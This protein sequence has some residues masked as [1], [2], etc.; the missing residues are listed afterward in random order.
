[1]M[2]RMVGLLLLCGLI[3]PRAASAE[4]HEVIVVFK[5][6]FDIG[7]TDMAANVVQRYRTTMID[8]ALEVV[9]RNRDLPPA[10]QFVWTIPGWPMHQILADWPGQTPQRQEQ[11]K[12]ALAE[13]RFVVH[14]LPFTT[15]TE[16]LEVEDLVRGLGYSSRLARGLG[17]ALP[18]DAKMTDVPEHTWMLSTLLRHAGVRFMHIG[19]NGWSAPL[20]VPPL[21][22]WEGPD[23]SRTLT[24]YSPDY[25]TRLMPPKDWP[26]NTW[27]ALL[28]TGDNEGPPRPEDVK[29]VLDQAAQE[30]PGVKVRIGRLSDFADALEAEKADLPVIR[31]D[32][33]DTW[34]HGPMSDPAGSKIA[35][36]L[37]PL[38]AATESLN[39]QLR[40]WGVT[41]PDATSTV[42]AAYEQSLL[43]G[44]HTWGGM[45]WWAGFG[46]IEGPISFGADFR[47][48]RASGRFRKIEAS[49]DEHTAYIEKAQ[50]L[51]TPVLQENLEVLARSVGHAGPRIV[52]YNP[53]PWKRDGLVSIPAKMPDAGALRPVDGGEDLAVETV[54]GQLRFVARDVPPM[55]YRT[56]VPAPR[57]EGVPPLLSSSSEEKKQGQDALAT[58]TPSNRGQD[59]RDT[60]DGDTIETAQF[61][62]TFDPA[63]GIVRSL[64][65]KASGRELVDGTKA[66]GFGQYLYERFDTKQ[67]NEYCQAYLRRP[68]QV[69]SPVFNKT[70]HPPADKFPYRA[71]SP[72]DFQLRVERSAVSVAVVME[73]RAQDNLPAV[74]TRVVLYPDQPYLDLEITLHDKP[75]DAVAEAGWLCLPLKVDAPQFRLGRLA[76]IIDPTRDILPGANRHVFGLNSGLA[77]TD[78]PG[79]GVGLCPLDSPLVSLDTPGLWKYTHDFVPRQP[80]VYVN[81]F[82]NQWNTNF[83]LWNSGTWTSRVR[84]WP[85]GARGEGVPPLRR[86]GILPAG[87]K[88]GQDALATEEQ[89][90]D[91][92]ATALITPALE[93]RYPLQAARADGPGGKLPAAQRG[94][95]LSPKGVLVTAFGR[96]P[97][98]P[99]TVLRLWEYA[100]H[101]GTCRVRLPAGLDI[102]QVQAVS[103][104][105]EP[106][107]APIPVPDGVF[108]VNLTGFA[109]AS[110]IIPT[111]S[112][113]RP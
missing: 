18:H 39:T 42:A 62:A 107:G 5:T 108:T 75:A 27:L 95:E 21:F 24:M 79:R 54:D 48:D 12:Q 3:V 6:H 92:L 89:G 68:E 109:P 64:V 56:Y 15:H 8:Q 63:R 80:I 46:R 51:L 94:L 32:A 2:K 77:V 43:Y 26:C 29:K 50:R 57:G 28:H 14:A 82:N 65:E 97:D 49:W 84:L 44:E 22:W 91:A 16:L 99:G 76:S 81:L 60:P 110:F 40:A 38:I 67:M 111:I 98:G 105:G 25:G 93:A 36:N 100:G 103:L 102:E 19:C 13:G 47:E 35:R 45:G 37:R 58:R 30:L 87:E 55:G 23:G 17:L 78:P 70:S 88:Q 33:P 10:Q 74:T 66:V 101:S 73:S 85:I 113:G 52:V 59:A 31:G 11:I 106:V 83:R 34:I 4:V 96:N 20:L 7:Y 86:A 72:K 104:R 1:M 90:Q 61:R 69:K 53:L 9:A 71:A 112:K 41:A